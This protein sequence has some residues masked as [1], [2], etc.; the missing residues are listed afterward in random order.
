MHGR[1]KNGE[2]REYIF[3]CSQVSSKSFFFLFKKRSG[4]R[5]EKSK[6][7]NGEIRRLNGN[8]TQTH[9]KVCNVEIDR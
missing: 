1:S 2:E 8:D 7:G 5:E 3:V 4:Q 6:A 9:K